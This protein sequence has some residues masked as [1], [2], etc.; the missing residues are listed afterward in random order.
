MEGA[1]EAGG[2]GLRLGASNL[3]ISSLPVVVSSLTGLLWMG[4]TT[5][6]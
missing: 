2:G 6:A 5:G 3:E 4:T 1:W